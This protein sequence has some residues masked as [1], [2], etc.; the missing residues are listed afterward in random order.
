M[1]MIH[2]YREMYA[3]NTSVFAQRL[4]KLRLE[5]GWSQ[6]EL[7]ERIDLEQSEVSRLERN[8]RR[9]SYDVLTSLAAAFGVTTDY[10]MGRSDDRHPQ[11]EPVAQPGI[12]RVPVVGDIS[13]GPPVIV[14]DN[15]EDY[16]A[17]PES[18]L[19]VG[20][21][22]AARV[23]GDSMERAN[24]RDGVLA[25]IRLQNIAEDRDI[26]A[27]CIGEEST[28]KRLRHLDGFIALVPESDNPEHK[29]ATYRE[30]EVRIVGVVIGTIWG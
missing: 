11:R 7:G 6:A 16:M 10:L 29:P 15:I 13:C 22:I 17:L 18:A 2:I 19:P 21:I 30:E 24:L 23:R 3:D 12:K 27:A 14:S 25:L 9:P 8:K 28:V 20:E 5:A 26:V 1:T 4:Q